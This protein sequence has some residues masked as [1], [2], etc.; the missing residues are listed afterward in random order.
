[1][2]L[3]ALHLIAVL[4]WMAGIFYLPR[5]FVYH[6]GVAP[7]SAA[8]DMLKTMERRLYRGIMAPA[9]VASW[10]FGL[11]LAWNTG[12]LAAPEIWFII[13][14]VGFVAMTGYHLWLGRFLG[15]FALDE[16]PKSERFF[17]LI[18]E[19]PTVLMIVIV[20]MAVVKPF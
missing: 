3:K 15:V 5:L 17:R 20:I 10:I 9:M 16:R 8:S 6:S 11:L 2:W 1:M 13:K 14:A 12:I 7:R 19:I 18:N 4:A